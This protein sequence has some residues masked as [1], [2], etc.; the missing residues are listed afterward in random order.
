MVGFW[1]C[2]E[3]I[4]RNHKVIGIGR[5]N[6][7]SLGGMQFKEVDLVNTYNLTNT[8]KSCEPDLIIHLA[9]N[10]NQK[11][12]E[13]NSKATWDL[14][15]ESSAL[16]ASF[17]RKR[18]AKLIHIS[19]EA[20]YGYAKNGLWS[21]SDICYPRGCYAITKRHAEDAI[22]NE[23]PNALVLRVTPVGVTPKTN[24]SSLVEWIVKTL[25]KGQIINGYQDVFFT[26]I[27]SK[28]LAKLI[29]NQSVR[30]LNGTYN[31]GI[32]ESI[33][34]CDFAMLIAKYLGY[35]SNSVIPIS[36]L[37]DGN[38]CQG[39]MNSTKLSTALGV[40]LPTTGELIS[41]LTVMVNGG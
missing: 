15:V 8:L 34:K 33:S 40:Q 29:L 35:P 36:K 18:N 11:T 26:P 9:A 13:E 32:H 38:I 24:Q 37:L 1:V 28:M 10:T 16:L 30:N 25:K 19:T 3:A 4:L 14:H 27:S 21:E 20:V 39:G 5:T 41:D 12:C 7:H 31:W 6:R 22:L 23:D 2:K 17:A